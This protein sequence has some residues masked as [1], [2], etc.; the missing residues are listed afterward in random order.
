MPFLK[1]WVQRSSQL[2][3]E[4]MRHVLWWILLGSQDKMLNQGNGGSLLYTFHVLKVEN[5]Y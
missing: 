1:S 4:L 2:W 3:G 5:T